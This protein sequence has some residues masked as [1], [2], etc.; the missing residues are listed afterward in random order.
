MRSP[1]RLRLN[2]VFGAS[3][4]GADGRRLSFLNFPCAARLEMNEPF[5]ATAAHPYMLNLERIVRMAP[6][7]TDEER[8]ALAEWAEEA[9]ESA[10]PIDTASWPGWRAVVNRLSH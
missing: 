9:L 3:S 7:M 1:R 4:H 6:N 5:E 8:A 10:T 2:G